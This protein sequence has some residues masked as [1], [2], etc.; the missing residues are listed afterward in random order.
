MKKLITAAA[1]TVAS[2]AFAGADKAEVKKDTGTDATEV[3]G[4]IREGAGEWADQAGM[5]TERQGTFKLKDA[6]SIQGTL[7]DPRG[8]R[9]TIAR[10][11]MPDASLDLRDDTMVMLDGKKVEM[12]ALP[13]GCEV[14]AKFQ[15]E[16]KETVA[17]KIDATHVADSKQG[18]KREK[19]EKHEGMKPGAN[20]DLKR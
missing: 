4:Q 14:R 2:I 8:G 16:G 7:K 19:Y 1:L 6:Y 13:E 15:L 12:K 3:S 9:V 10:K 11:G 18:G 5:A 17:L 20:D